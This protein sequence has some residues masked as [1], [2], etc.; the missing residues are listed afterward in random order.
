MSSIRHRGNQGFF[1]YG[2]PIHA[3]PGVHDGAFEKLG[4][5][6][7]PPA[8]I[9]EMGAGS[10]A[11]TRRMVDAGFQVEAV[12]HDPPE[13]WPLAN[14][15]LHRQDL[16]S[17]TWSLPAARYDAA[18]AIEVVE[19]LENP[20]LFFRNVRR[21]LKPGGIVLFTTPNI[22]SVDSRRKMLLKGELAFFGKGTLFDIG[23]MSPLPFWLLEDILVKE[24]YQIVERFFVGRLGIFVRAGRALWKVAIVPWIDLALF[25]LGWGIP[26]AAAFRTNL[27]IV[28]RPA[29]DS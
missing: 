12:D 26:A 27:G 7:K 8:T 16:N 10:G 22:M 24:R 9:L 11:F 5:H 13:A 14:V 21:L 20:T 25:A 15:P 3:P 6:V 17:E 4:R 29:G 28:A 1:Y 18:V 23:H 19:H 2:I